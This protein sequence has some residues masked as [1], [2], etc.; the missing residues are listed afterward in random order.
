MDH[1]LEDDGRPVWLPRD[2]TIAL[3]KMAEHRIPLCVGML[4]I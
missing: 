3:Q 4:W 1:V 2:R